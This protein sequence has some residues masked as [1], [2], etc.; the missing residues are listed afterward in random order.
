M[1]ETEL[2]GAL[3]AAFRRL[4][5]PLVRILLRNSVGFAEY[6][7]I[8]RQV[9]VDVASHDFDEPKKNVSQARI[10]IVTGMT[11]K[12]IGRVIAQEKNRHGDLGSNL[13]R[14]M[15]VLTGWHTDPEFNGPYGLP[16]E[17]PF[18]APH[19]RSFTTLA[20]RYVG[21]I[22]AKVLLD[23]LLRIGVVKET[24]RGSYKVLTRTYM[25]TVDAPDSLDRLAL[26]VRSFI[27]TVDY[28]RIENDP[29]KKLFER[30]VVADNGIR[31]EDLPHFQAYL[32]ERGQ[33]LLEEIDDWLSQLKK[34][35]KDDERI[36]QTGVG[37]YH[38][39]Q[40]DKESPRTAWTRN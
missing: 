3:L 37:I 17:V 28:N 6:V 12:E 26:A 31:E 19:T 38:Y 25:P 15:K 10:A 30:T 1:P 39:V 40:N 21:D 22:P 33:L 2:K 4:L 36:L 5:R 7:E 14:V 16:L 23:D 8:S 9:F 27:E 11:R 13:G 34:P 18:T 24:E 32:R 35:S 20:Q 29:D